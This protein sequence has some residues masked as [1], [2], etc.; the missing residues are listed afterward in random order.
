M[1]TGLGIW[2]RTWPVELLNVPHFSP[3]DELLKVICSI[4]GTSH[5]IFP[6][7]LGMFHLCT[8]AGNRIGPA[9]QHVS[10]GWTTHAYDVSWG[11]GSGGAL[12]WGRSPGAPT[13]PILRPTSTF[14]GTAMVWISVCSLVLSGMSL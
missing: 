10:L 3:F 2:W 13:R 4:R 8:G 5:F 6:L 12:Q 9:L 11:W 7:H 14:S 1:S